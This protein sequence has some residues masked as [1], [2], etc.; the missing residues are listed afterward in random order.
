NEK[1][2]DPNISAQTHP[3]RLAGFTNRKQKYKDEKGNYPFVR[4]IQA[5]EVISEKVKD[6][7]K[8]NGSKIISQNLLK[9]WDNEKKLYASGFV[10]IEFEN[11]YKNIK[12]GTDLSSIDFK[13]ALVGKEKGLNQEQI[14]NIIKELSPDLAQRHPNINNY[15]DLTV[16]NVFSKTPEQTVKKSFGR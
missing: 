14:E 16:K 8:I 15:V 3:F 11:Y 9:K 5:I 7:V 10:K 2:G 12:A 1:Y 4:I 6:F 13:V